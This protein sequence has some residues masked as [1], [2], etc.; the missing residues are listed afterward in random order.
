MGE[1]IFLIDGTAL[2]YRSHF[3][4]M[5]APL[6]TSSGQNVSAVFGVAQT[7][8][9][10][11]RG[12]EARFAAVALD[13]AAPTFRHE[14]Y[15][16]YKAQR[17]PMPEDLALQLPL[18]RE[19]IDALGLVILQREGVEADD[20]IASLAVE[21]A[22]QGHEAV[23]V[24]ADKDFN[25]LVG[26]GVVQYVPAR[27]KESPVWLG[28][29][30]VAE[31]WGVSAPQVLDVLALAG[32]A[33]DNIPGVRGIGEKTAVELIR[34]FGDLDSLYASLDAVERASIREKLAA[35]RDEAFLSRDLIRLRRDLLPGAAIESF[36]VPPIGSRPGLLEL[37]QRLEF[38]RLIEGLDLRPAAGEWR[39]EYRLADDEESLRAALATRPDGA[40]AISVDTETDSLDARTARAVGISFAW[41]AGR[42]FYI[43][44]GHREGRNL[45]PARVAALLQPILADPAIEKVGQ[46][47]K[48]DLHVLTGLGIRVEPPLFDTLLASYLL[49]PDRRHDLDSLTLELLGHRKIPT[50][51]LIG[52][53]KAQTTMDR[54]QPD[55]VKDYAGEDADAA[56]RLREIL[57]PSL[58]ERGQVELFRSIE[59][60]LIQVLVSM[61]RAGVHVD[62]AGLRAL[63][64][65]MEEEQ[66]RQLEEITRLA[67]VEFNVQS[68]Q[69]LGQ[70]LFERL[71]LPRGKKTK[72][73]YSTDSEVL[74]EL[75]VDHP[76]AGAVLAYRQ[77]AKL[78][79]T[80]VDALP[81]LVDP[82]TGRL[83]AQFHQAVAATG[84]LSS[85]DPNLQN[86]P[87]RTSQGRR[88][89]AAFTPQQAGDILISADYSQ[90]EL[91]I[92]AHLS[93]DEGL[94]QAFRAGEDIHAAT[95][96]RIFDLPADKID[97]ATRARAKT[98]NFGVL[99]GMGPVRLSREMGIPLAEAR[100]FIDQYFAKMPGVRR[101]LEEGLESARRD[102]YVS[103]IL[104]RR[105]Y[106]P[107]L[108]SEDARSRAQAERIAANTP[109]QGSAADLIKAAMIRV[110]RLL[111]AGRLRTRLILQVH[112]ELLF[113]GP[114][115]E[116]E[117]VTALA[118][119]AMETAVDIAVPLKVDVGSGESWDRAHA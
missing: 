105:R 1:R 83:H 49:D 62:T 116:R 38:R 60:P 109:I 56:F 43:P 26:P 87:V 29:A 93:Q 74:E 5:R 65:E 16:A 2:I 55:A 19:L 34:R 88:I 76:I 20:L 107:A 51:D 89:R 57:D 42:A 24:S 36:R 97:P 80:Y 47:L 90:I 25:Q 82:V 71:K 106:L 68:P 96:A 111:T 118:R 63:G 35:H 22:S 31:R 12:E 117:T 101:Y 86:I 27:G 37:L 32:D 69:Q 94:L 103:T 67:G 73:G 6:T 48:F 115:S 110:D 70:V 79:S 78:R 46:N 54:L 85:S 7:L 13:T 61:E 21:A 102:G 11:L 40:A 113:E 3:A 119:E 33:V 52:S 100:K 91:R 99:Y 114:A 104:G 75:A 28:P 112:D 58:R 45:D 92:L 95:A 4:F 81:R 8:L 15:E 9:A 72:T 23:I 64:G 84:R 14:R 17:P 10:V 66:R 30:E 41:E 53:G 59:A 98:V 50:K 18:V 44:L 39:G 77:T 108:R